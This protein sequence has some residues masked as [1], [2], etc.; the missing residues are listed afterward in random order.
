MKILILVLDMS[1]SGGVERVTSTLGNLL[2]KNHEVT[3]LSVFGEEFNDYYE[4]DKKVIRINILKNN[5]FLHDSIKKVKMHFKIMMEILKFLNA[6]YNEYDYIL[7]MFDNLSIYGSFSKAKSKIIAVQHGDYFA[8]NKMI[9]CI[10]KIRYK[11]LKAIVSLTEDNREKYL[12]INN[13][14]IKKIENP[15]PFNIDGFSELENKKM[16]AVGRLVKEKGFGNLI[17]IVEPV[18]KKYNWTLDIFGDGILK[19]ELAD[20]IKKYNLEDYIFLRGN[21]NTIK[22]EYKQ[23]TIYLCSSLT[24]SFSMTLLEAMA[25]GLAVVSYDCPNGPRE[26][27]DNEFNGILVENQ[28]RDQ[29]L[30]NLVRLVENPNRVKKLGEK[31]IEKAKEFQGENILEKWEK[32]FLD[33]REK[34]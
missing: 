32:L 3:I 26:L 5:F 34:N 18:L 17:E 33:L 25:C 24:E 6:N 20:K 14:N 21:T 12:I 27:I 19:K 2:V 16:I 15:L 11:R 22:E 30:E 7:S 4:I 28:N 29:F 1:I 13:K 9:R 23:A 8:H 10:R 31:A